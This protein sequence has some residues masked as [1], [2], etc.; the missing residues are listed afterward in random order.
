MP[1]PPAAPGQIYLVSA[2]GTWHGQTIIN[3]MH[4]RTAS[5]TVPGTVEN[6]YDDIHA[7][8]AAG[9]ALLPIF[10]TLCP[11]EY[12]LD[13]LWVQLIQPTRVVKKLYNVGLPGINLNSSTTAN[14]QATVV[15]RG[16]LANRKQQGAIRIPYPTLH[17]GDGNGNVS[18]A[19]RVVMEALGD[20]LIGTL[21]G[22]NAEYEHVLFN[23]ANSPSTQVLCESREAKLTVRTM[24]RRTVGRGI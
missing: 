22:T 19:Y 21:S 5:I 14:L 7:T 2:V 23:K 20:K 15:R 24:R 1:Y 12:S 13:A 3:T 16:I 18:N 17:P 11:P 4:L 6:I 10:L 8:L 9:T